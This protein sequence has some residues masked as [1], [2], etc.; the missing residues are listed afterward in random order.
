MRWPLPRDK[1]G[2][3]QKPDH[4]L[5][6]QV[7]ACAARRRRCR[8]EIM[9]RGVKGIVQRLALTIFRCR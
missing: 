4:F 2:F 8:A 1:T 7:G 9:V 3:V 5:E 6:E